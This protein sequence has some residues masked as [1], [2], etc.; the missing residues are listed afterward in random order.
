MEIKAL[1]F[2]E[3]D[4]ALPN[5]GFNPFHTTEALRV[6]DEHVS[7]D[8]YLF[9]GFKGDHPVGLAPI[10]V[11]ENAIGRFVMSP[12]LGVGIGRLGPIVMPTSPK[13]RK[14]EKVNKTFTQEVIEA[15]GADDATTLVRLRCDPEYGDPRPFEWAGFKI[16]PAFTYQLDLESTTPDEV[17][18]S[19]SR[20][21]R[22]DIQSGDDTD[23]VIRTD[24][25]DGLKEVFESVQERYREQDLNTPTSWP[26]VR[27][28]VSA[29]NDRVRVYTAESANGEVLS[30]VIVLYS[31]E[32]A[33]HWK[34]GTK[35][36]DRT[37]D[38]SPNSLLHWRIIEDIVTDPA[39]D[40]VGRYDLYEANDERLAEYKSSFGGGLSPYYIVE[41]TGLPMMAAKGVYRM[42]YLNKN[43]TGDQ[44]LRSAV[45]W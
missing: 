20:S 31:N 26:F 34:G 22:R 41:S 36:S 4:D 38:V 2:S 15:V 24:R 13:Q 39:L 33:Y 30:G 45:P 1:D 43:P 14:R 40:S 37:F 25:D 32:T 23:I 27:D 16:E 8:L 18:S 21:L 5:S 11:Q 3:W 17:L 12:P 28:V 19:F 6:I 42:A 7:G 10:V 44:S 29:L 35:H 9:G